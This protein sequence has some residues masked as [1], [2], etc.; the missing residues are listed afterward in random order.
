MP[1]EP[2]LVD[3]RDLGEL[4]LPLSISF[5][6]L[7]KW[8]QSMS[9]KLDAKLNMSYVVVVTLLNLS[10]AVVVT[11]LVVRELKRLES[12]IERS[13]QKVSATIYDTYP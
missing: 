4:S 8:K 1:R 11:L 9:M 5:E 2:T 10:Y 3:R 12:S 6:L 13:T 7:T